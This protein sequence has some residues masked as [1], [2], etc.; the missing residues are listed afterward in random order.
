MIKKLILA[1]AMLVLLAGC[2]AKQ[3]LVV[4]G[5]LEAK[6]IT[7]SAETGGIVKEVPVTEGAQVKAGDVLAKIDPTLLQHQVDQAKAALAMADARAREVG[8][9]SRSEQV[10]S[11]RANLEQVQAMA[12]GA[13]NMIKTLE[14][15][16]ADIQKKIDDLKNS[17]GYSLNP[18]Y[19]QQVASLEG[20]KTNLNIQLESTRSQLTVYQAQVK[21]AQAQ[22]DL[23]ASGATSQAKEAALAQVDQAKA[24]LAM[25]DARAREVGAGSRSEQV[26]S[27]KANLEQVQAM[28]A[29][30][31]NMIKT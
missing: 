5:N 19:Q 27:A 11:A 18:G 13:Q 26:R 3:Q 10:R 2:N 16:I 29:G 4:S 17:T 9:G 22:Y 15:S 24:A 25:A 12:A 8:A 30:A 21:A 6:E 1:L 20:S 14:G 28:A 7:I 23:V 31:Q